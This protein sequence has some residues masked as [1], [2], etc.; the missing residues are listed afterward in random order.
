MF[1]LD[2]SA[3]EAIS[4]L[5]K[6][7]G[8]SFSALGLKIE[9]VNGEKTDPTTQFEFLPEKPTGFSEVI[10]KDLRV[11]TAPEASEKL[12]NT[13]LQYRNDLTNRGFVFQGLDGGEGGCGTGC[14]SEPSPGSIAV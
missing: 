3:Y 13:I 12:Q 1:S 2:Q 6:N 4:G 9:F 8:Y 11:W 7:R 5:L 10:F 14:S